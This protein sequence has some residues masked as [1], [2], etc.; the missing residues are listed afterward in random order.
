MGKSCVGNY[1]F[2]NSQ[3]RT[4]PGEAIPNNAS[5]TIWNNQEIVKLQLHEELRFDGI[6]ALVRLHV[7]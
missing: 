6:L 5:D 3:N 1:Y 4:S 7:L 2:P